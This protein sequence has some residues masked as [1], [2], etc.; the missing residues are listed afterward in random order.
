MHTEVLEVALGYHRAQGVGHAAYAELYRRAVAEVGDDV[1]GY[2]RVH[3]ARRAAGQLDG[4]AVLALDHQVDLGDVHALLLAAHGAGQT[5]EHLY[6]HDVRVVYVRAGVARGDG[7]VEVAVLVHR[8]GADEG[9]VYV[10]EG[11]VE[12]AQVAVEHGLT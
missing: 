3:L 8:R 7:E 5:L 6:D 4:R 1:R 10:Q 11:V 2:L 12:P 9:H